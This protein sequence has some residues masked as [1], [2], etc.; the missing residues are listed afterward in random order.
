MT[1][2]KSPLSLAD[3]TTLLDRLTS[4]EAFRATFKQHP[5]T[6]LRQISAEAAAAAEGCMLSA[7][8]ASS[9]DLAAARDN[10]V[11]QLTER[12]VFSHPHCFI[13]GSQAP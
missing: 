1:N 13:D 3:A 11:Q 10:L 2:Q 8:L 5:A 12:S 7:D 6:A 9:E 4:D